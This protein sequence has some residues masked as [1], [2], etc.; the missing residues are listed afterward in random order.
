[1]RRFRRGCSLSVLALLAGLFG[2]SEIAAREYKAVVYLKRPE[3]IGAPVPFIEV[4]KPRINQEKQVVM[5]STS[6]H[7]RSQY[8]KQPRIDFDRIHSLGWSDKQGM[9][10]LGMIDGTRRDCYCYPANAKPPRD[11]SWIESNAMEAA[12]F[13]GQFVIQGR[14]VKTELALREIKKIYFVD[15]SASLDAIA[16]QWAREENSIDAWKEFQR[17]FP[18]SAQASVAS[19]SLVRLLLS[20]SEDNWKKFRNG[21]TLA[22]LRKAKALS[23]EALRIRSGEASA[24]EMKKAAAEAEQEVYARAERMSSLVGQRQ[25]DQALD[26][27]REIVRF[28]P[29]VPQIAELERQALRGSHDLHRQAAREYA[30]A[31]RLEQGIAEYQMALGRLEDAETRTELREANIQLALQSAEKARAAQDLQSANEILKQAINLH[32]SDPRLEKLQ[33]AVKIQWADRLFKQAAPLYVIPRI[34]S[35]GAEEKHLK[36]L[37]Y[38]EQANS[39]I[40]RPET[41]KAVREIRR[42]LAAYYFQLGQKKMALPRGAAVGQARLY[43]LRAESYDNELR[44]LLETL[45]R[46][47]EAFRN[48]SSVGVNV[49][50]TDKS[51]HKLCSHIAG[52][53]EGFIGQELTQAG[54]PNVQVV[55]REE[56]EKLKKEEAITQTHSETELMLNVQGAAVQVLGDILVCDVKTQQRASSAPSQYISGY[57]ENPEYYRLVQL[58]DQSSNQAQA[59][60]QQDDAYKACA[61][62]ERRANVYGQCRA[63]RDQYKREYDRLRNLEYQASTALQNTPAQF[64]II[65][66]YSYARRDITVQGGAKVG[67]R[68]VDSLSSVRRQQEQLTAEDARSGVEIRGT[69]AN[70]T[71]SV[72]DREA[73]VPSEDELLEQLVGSLRKKIADATVAFLRN[74]GEKYLER[75]HLARDRG[76]LDDA[77]ENYILFL[78]TTPQK[79]GPD[80]Q[81]AE[82]FLRAKRNLVFRPE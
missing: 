79:G 55:E 17:V 19:E 22:D 43:L 33:A 6:R 80:C 1:M 69:M 37:T 71:K 34:D 44:G 62:Q 58:R 77:V 9:M 72:T 14:K 4:Y 82:Q 30:N 15:E 59:I 60:D 66:A 7:N 46:A 11:D 50:F 2:V 32:G 24:L 56:F 42:R 12:Q 18:E 61:E 25:W 73:N 13:A 63:V 65:T 81:E 67:Y 74:F 5:G 70:D 16:F 36:A 38:L 39:L 28:A 51:M 57:R 29:E 75:A 45:E 52:E 20:A 3:L 47:R 23:E 31:G 49:A 21:G 48:K 78:A 68:I 76:A 54:L 27:H 64:P 35:E 40:P 8:G 10:Q 53:I 41:E 26:A